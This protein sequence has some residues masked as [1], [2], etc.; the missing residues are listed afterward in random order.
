LLGLTVAKIAPL[1][2]NEENDGTIFGTRGIGAVSVE[3]WEHIITLDRV[4][5]MGGREDADEPSN[6][7]HRNFVEELM[8]QENVIADH[9]P[10]VLVEGPQWGDTRFFAKW[11]SA[12]GKAERCWRDA[13]KDSRSAEAVERLEVLYTWSFGK[14]A[15]ALFLELEGNFIGFAIPLEGE[16]IMGFFLSTGERYQMVIPTRLTVSRAKKAAIWLAETEDA[17]C[18]LHPER[19][20]KYM[21][22]IEAKA[23]QKRLSKIPQDHRIADRRVLLEDGVHP[24]A[25]AKPRGRPR[26]CRYGATSGPGE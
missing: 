23:W 4:R 11:L 15:S 8:I 20:V 21:T 24:F 1:R 13:A 9:D 12:A 25:A 19:L 17:E 7:S 14:G 5:E 10:C 18:E 2:P 16:L 22:F 26:I 3:S 6:G